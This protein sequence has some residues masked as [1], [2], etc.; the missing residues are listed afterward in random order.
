MVALRELLVSILIN[1][2]GSKFI[3]TG[4]SSVSIY[5]NCRKNIQ[6][7]LQGIISLVVDPRL[8]FISGL[9]ILLLKHNFVGIRRSLSFADAWWSQFLYLGIWSATLQ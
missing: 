7:E 8:P 1:Q 5:L 9:R 6:F 2:L 3:I 4:F